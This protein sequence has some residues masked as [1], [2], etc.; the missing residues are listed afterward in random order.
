MERRELL[1]GGA[2]AD[3]VTSDVE[4]R[5]NHMFKPLSWNP[6]DKNFIGTKFIVK[7]NFELKE[8]HRV[9]AEGNIMEN[10]WGGFTQVG[11]NILVTPKNQA[12]PNGTN[13]CPICFVSDVT[14]TPS[15][16]RNVIAQV[17]VNLSVQ[18]SLQICVPHPRRAPAALRHHA[19]FTKRSDTEFMQ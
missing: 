5:L 11:A 16:M 13:I 7:N 1:F 17:G 12:G 3:V 15:Y 14:F 10:T 4:I 18:N 9:L 19:N 8:G 2:T 6:R